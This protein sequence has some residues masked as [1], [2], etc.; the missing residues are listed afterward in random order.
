[1]SN[2]HQKYIF[3]TLGIVAGVIVSLI[4]VAPIGIKNAVHRI[5]VSLIAGFIFAAF[6]PDLPFLEQLRGDTL[7]HWMAQGFVVGSMVY[8]FLEVVLRLISSN[9]WLVEVAK[10]IIRIRGSKR[11]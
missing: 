11:E 8:F 7:N 9:D 2:D 5:I 3:Q 6:V 1:M 10:E 4:I